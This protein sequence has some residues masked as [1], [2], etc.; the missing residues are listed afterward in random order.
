[1][2][3][4]RHSVEWD[5]Q[6]QYPERQTAAKRGHDQH[7]I[8]E[9]QDRPRH[10]GGYSKWIHCDLRCVNPQKASHGCLVSSRVPCQ[11]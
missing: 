10:S 4:C 3:A 6:G 11:T 1:M 8:E 2:V 7:Q 9:K 5:E